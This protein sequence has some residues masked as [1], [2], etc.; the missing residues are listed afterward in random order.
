MERNIVVIAL[1]GPPC[2]GKTTWAE[3]A[4]AEFYDSSN[5][6]IMHLSR[7]IVR[8]ALFNS[9]NLDEYQERLV[10]TK[11][12]ASVKY[13]LSIDKGVVILDNCHDSKAEIDALLL[14]L[15]SQITRGTAKFYIKVFHVP[16]WKLVL[17]NFRRL[18]GGK[19]IPLR[20]IRQIQQRI[21]KTNFDQHYKKYLYENMADK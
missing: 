15:N 17:R 16:F 3:N 4:A 8:I 10:N 13:A 12:Y 6:P 20:H 21:E 1:V 11:Y 5:L 9:Y 14:T 19:W 7:D 18:F 2:S